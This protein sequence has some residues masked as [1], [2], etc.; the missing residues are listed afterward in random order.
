MFFF[1]FIFSIRWLK[2]ISIS[3]SPYVSGVVCSSHCCCCHVVWPSVSIVLGNQM[4]GRRIICNQRQAEPGFPAISAEGCL[5]QITR[6]YLVKINLNL[7]GNQG[8]S[9]PLSAN[10]DWGNIN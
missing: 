4:V 6:E 9:V 10:P 3:Y 2:S 5:Q 1:I 7:P 8:Q